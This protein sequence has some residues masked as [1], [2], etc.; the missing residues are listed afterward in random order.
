MIN[1]TQFHRFQPDTLSDGYC[2]LQT[3][4]SIIHPMLLLVTSSSNLLKGPIS[5]TCMVLGTKL[6]SMDGIWAAGL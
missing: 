5:I 6:G 1:H 2:V 4:R 3:S